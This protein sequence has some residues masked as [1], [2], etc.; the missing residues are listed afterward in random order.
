[1]KMYR[2]GTV[3][4][5]RA[6]INDDHAFFPLRKTMRVVVPAPIGATEEEGFKRGK[7]EPVFDRA[8]VPFKR[9]R[10]RVKRSQAAKA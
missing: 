10:K 3:L 5:N 6:R 2:K 8:Y 1:M 9:R 4:S 7:H